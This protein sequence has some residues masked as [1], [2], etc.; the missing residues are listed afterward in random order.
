MKWNTQSPPVKEEQDWIPLALY[1]LSAMFWNERKDLLDRERLDRFGHKPGYLAI[2][3]C[4]DKTVEYTL[5]MLI[6]KINMCSS[7]HRFIGIQ[8]EWKSTKSMCLTVEDWSCDIGAWNS[9]FRPVGLA[10]E[11]I[12]YWVYKLRWWNRRSL[13]DWLIV[14]MRTLAL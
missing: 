1:E 5:T 7:H 13:R 6:C 2:I 8:S 9:F 14:V 11:S 10:I 12:R 4:L 3:A